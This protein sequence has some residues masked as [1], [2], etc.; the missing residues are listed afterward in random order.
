MNVCLYHLY[1]PFSC[2]RPALYIPFQSRIVPQLN[3]LVTTFFCRIKPNCFFHVKYKMYG[4]LQERAQNLEELRVK[5]TE[6]L[7][8][9]PPVLEIL[10]TYVVLKDLI[11]AVTA[12]KN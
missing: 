8:S 10:F 5:I 1:R 12:I 6:V 4:D 9:I 7:R 11:L 3:D 2:I